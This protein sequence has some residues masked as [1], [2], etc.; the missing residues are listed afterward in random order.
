[1]SHCQLH[2]WATGKHNRNIGGNF[3]IESQCGQH[4]FRNFD[5]NRIFNRQYCI[6]N[7]GPY[8]GCLKPL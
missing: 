5:E 3:K 4:Y 7:E 8:E 6:V 2:C 1:M